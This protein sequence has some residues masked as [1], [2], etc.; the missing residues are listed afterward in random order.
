MTPADFLRATAEGTRVVVRY[1]L[2]DDAAAA[3]D[4]VGFVSAHGATS[5]VIATPRG[6]QTIALD[7]VIAAKEVPPPP[8]KR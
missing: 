7:D 6:L 1:R 8:V 3:T 5:V 2:H 4:A